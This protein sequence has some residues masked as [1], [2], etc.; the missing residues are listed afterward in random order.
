MKTFPS[1]FSLTAFESEMDYLPKG[2]EDYWTQIQD[3]A[4]EIMSEMDYLPKGNED[5]PNP[6]SDWGLSHMS[7]M[8]Y[9]PK[10]NEDFQDGE[11]TPRLPN[12]PK[13]TICRKA[14][15]THRSYSFI[16]FPFGSEMD[17]LPKG[18]EDTISIQPTMAVLAVRNGLFA[19]RQ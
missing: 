14:M 18:N 2:N 9:L 4:R 17:Y 12:R 10:G 6:F 16:V 5:V 3:D 11:Q 19:E 7:E 15:K 13:W 1:I 8:D